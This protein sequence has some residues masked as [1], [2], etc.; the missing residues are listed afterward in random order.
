[1]IHHQFLILWNQIFIWIIFCILFWNRFHFA[2]LFLAPDY[3]IFSLCELILCTPATTYLY[4]FLSPTLALLFRPIISHFI[5]VFFLKL[6][7]IN[8]SLFIDV[9]LIS[10]VSRTVDMVWS[11]FNSCNHFFF[12]L[13]IFFQFIMYPSLLICSQ[14]NVSCWSIIT[15]ILESLHNLMQFIW[16]L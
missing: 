15:I 2:F 13:F 8:N 7:S 14:H 5:T 4:S 6:F 11:G 1:M 12:Y 10:G 16:C 3:I 9:I